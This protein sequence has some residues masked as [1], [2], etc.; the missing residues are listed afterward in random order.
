MSPRTA[1]LPATDGAMWRKLLSRVHPDAG[2]EHELFIWTRA[3]QE[4]VLALGS[5]AGEDPGYRAAG[6]SSAPG[7]PDRV[8]FP[9]FVD[10]DLLTAH[11]LK[12]AAEV[13]QPYAGV[14][15]LLAGC[16]SLPGFEGQEQ[17]GATFKQLALIAHRAGMSKRERSGWYEIAA[18]IPLSQRHA[19]HLIERLGERA[20]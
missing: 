4:H 9:P 10:H 13:G 15:R 8:D 12:V 6:E 7:Q 19:G 1:T 14:L 11:A 17:R 18:R 16:V 3:V 20:A 5:F 2:G